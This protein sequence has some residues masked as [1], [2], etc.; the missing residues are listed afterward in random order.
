MEKLTKT[1]RIVDVFAKI[2]FIFCI[3]A[4]CMLIAADIFMIASVMALPE[5]KLPETLSVVFDFGDSEFVVF[6]NGRLMVTKPQLV[7]YT[8]TLSLTAATAAVI[9]MIGAKLVRRILSP[10]KEGRPFEEGISE[11]IKKFGHFVLAATIIGAFIQFL[12]VIVLAVMDIAPESAPVSI[13]TD[14]IFMAIVIYLISYIFR[15][16]EELQKQADETL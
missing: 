11:I 10:M 8:L 4:I 1:A 12:L 3:V 9:L 15:Y 2:L 6:E 5:D 16:G 13:S 14:G 7:A